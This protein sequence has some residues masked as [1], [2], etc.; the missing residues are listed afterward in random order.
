MS[1]FWVVYNISVFWFIYSLHRKHK[2]I[3][4]AEE[5]A[6]EERNK[7]EAAE[8]Q[9]ALGAKARAK[10]ATATATTA[11]NLSNTAKNTADT[12]AAAST[13]GSPTHAGAVNKG[14]VALQSPGV[15]IQMA[16]VPQML[17][18]L[19]AAHN[20]IAVK[21]QI[22]AQ[23]G[24][25]VQ[26]SGSSSASHGGGPGPG[27]AAAV[28]PQQQQQPV[29][30][31]TLAPP[32]MP[33]LPPPQQ[34]QQPTWNAEAPATGVPAALLLPMN[35]APSSGSSSPTSGFT[36]A[37]PAMPSIPALP[38]TVAATGTASEPAVTVT[39]TPTSHS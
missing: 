33:L 26:S 37:M 6:I 36:G 28:A 7:R 2:A 10:L 12:I 17:S 15:Q 3:D 20:N 30:V 32:V 23:T 13:N 34:Q 18:S 8:R 11:T 39:V 31:A 25:V 1:G 22:E 35:P 19:A 38:Q 16:L 27:G 4:A 21:A 5:L 29:A 24:I 14:Q 9:E